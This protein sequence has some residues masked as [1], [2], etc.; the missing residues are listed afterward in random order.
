MRASSPRREQA[1]VGVVPRNPESVTSST[2]SPIDSTR[3]ALVNDTTIYA[4]YSS[5]VWGR[6]GGRGGERG[7]GGEGERGGRGGGERGR[8]GE[9]GEERGREGE[10]GSVVSNICCM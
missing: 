4:S 9:R 6:E 2:V 3:V 1:R 5:A 7:R 10:R 8:E